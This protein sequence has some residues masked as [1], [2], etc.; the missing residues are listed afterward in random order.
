M[1]RGF[2][3]RKYLI[4]NYIAHVGHIGNERADKLAKEGALD[5]VMHSDIPKRPTSFRKQ[6]LKTRLYEAWEKEWTAGQHC[7]Q[8]K[9]WF[10][11][12]NQK[13]SRQ[14]L[15][16]NRNTYSMMIQLITGHNYLNYHHSLVSQNRN[17]VNV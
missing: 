6:E 7:R 17:A 1:L 10:P 15:M 5:G 9:Y 14:L 11:I 8:T 4:N 13:L 16:L 3:Q 2:L 12:P